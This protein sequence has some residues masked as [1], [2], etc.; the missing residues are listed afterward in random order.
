MAD[1]A[2]PVMPELL[3]D[4]TQDH[5]RTGTPLRLSLSI[6]GIGEVLCSDVFRVIGE[7]ALCASGMSEAR[8][9]S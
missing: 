4:V 9:S 5:A 7:N 8:R 1:T 2:R 3:G 6:P